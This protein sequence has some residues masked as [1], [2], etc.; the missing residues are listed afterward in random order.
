MYSDWTGLDHV[1]VPEPITVT[2]E[3]DI[4]IGLS[5]ITWTGKW[6]WFP[7]HLKSEILLEGERIGAGG[8]ASEMMATGTC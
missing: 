8:G 7:L 2:R 3:R 5:Q 6:R 1:L 4:L